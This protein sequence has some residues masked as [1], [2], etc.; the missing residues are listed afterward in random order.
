MH[1]LVASQ[2]NLLADRY[3]IEAP[4]GSGGMAIV[5][6]ARDLRHGRLVA[7]KMLRP[8]I[9]ILFGVERFRREIE[10]ASRLQHPNILPVFDSGEVDG[11]LYYVMPYADGD[12]LRARLD[13]TGPLPVAEAVSIACEVADALVWAHR[14]GVIHRDIKP[15]N[16][17]F[18]AGHAL[19]A[20]FGIAR[21]LDDGVTGSSELTQ[22]GLGLGTPAYMSPE[23][24]FGETVDGRTD[25]YAL[26]CV[27][28]EMLTGAA[29]FAGIASTAML[30]QKTTREVPPPK[31]PY[32]IP[33]HVESAVMSALA[34]DAGSRL[35]S[36]EELLRVLSHR[37][38]STPLA[39]QAINPHV[40]SI[41]VLPFKNVGQSEEDRY[42][43]DGLTDE[44][45]HALG[46]TRGLRVLGR[47]TTFAMR[48]NDTDALRTELKVDT[49][50]HGS[51]RRGGDR[52]RIMAHLVDSKSGFELWS[53]RYDRPLT[54]V[55][56]IQDEITRAIVEALRAEL[57]ANTQGP[58]VANMDA[59]ERYLKARYHWHRR[60]VTG[61]QHSIEYLKESL[62]RETSFAAASSAL[63]EG[64]V[65][66][67]IYGAVS[68][69][70]AM[71]D[72][73][74]AAE[75]ALS[76][77]P[78]L[79]EA[80]SALA[81]VRAM[82]D[83]DW[84][85]AAH[86]FRASIEAS[87]QYS[88]A[89]QWYAMHLMV[90]RKQ[91]ALGFRQLMRAHELDPL[92]PSIGLSLGITHFFARDYESA[93]DA[94]KSLVRRDTEFAPGHAFL[95]QVHAEM[96]NPV[97]GL[98]H[99][100][101]AVRL[102]GERPEWV[103]ASGVAYARAGDEEGARAALTRLRALAISDYVSPVLRAQVHAALEDTDRALDDIDAAIEVRA[104]D[105]IW[106]GVRPVFES[107]RQSSRFQRQLV[108]IG[109]S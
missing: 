20:D 52:L 4:A 61:M 100:D 55:F 16:I 6:R 76:L 46:A 48:D 105:L 49:L 78:G 72:A 17:L 91:F 27:L 21:A 103:A 90:P 41:A 9:S 88:T 109:L 22:P 84:V 14:S 67:A 42:F 73:R 45:I 30:L 7:L 81:S 69:A 63:A 71:A 89:H 15:E 70:R 8:E 58:A 99:I 1:D 64:Y 11:V 80:L 33:P 96:G 108:H 50:L 87:P 104:T 53:A 59:Y 35:A 51:V 40:P 36:A 68:P 85:G 18:S 31:G 43:S 44:L 94:F 39:V 12:S 66:L 93:L 107:L 13:A 38:A 29:P 102:V 32:A 101:E 3:A 95:G 62:A 82:W 19:V 25:V 106:M 65:T 5:Y 2:P 47:S 77:H 34:R 10:I 97:E 26:G 86:D 75:H 98:K 57:L 54:D 79:G 37:R 23:Q 56:A 24:A 74:A 92:S 28:Y 83:W 60:S